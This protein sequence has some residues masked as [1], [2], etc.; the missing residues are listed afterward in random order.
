MNNKYELKITS[1]AARRYKK[2][3]ANNKQLQKKVQDTLSLLVDDPF[4]N[5][6]KTHKVQI[7]N[8]GNVYSSSIT[9]DIRIIWDFEKEKVTIILLDIGGHSGSK[10]V[11]K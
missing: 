5:K 10:G 6:L 4:H 1:K 7:S 3:I 8:Y 9:G 11:Y 2:L